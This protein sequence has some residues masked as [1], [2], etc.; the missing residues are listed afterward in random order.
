MSRTFPGVPGG[1]LLAQGLAD[2]ARGVPSLAACLVAM[3]G[4]RLETLGLLAAGAVD[5][6][7]TG[8]AFELAAYRLLAVDHGV[9][10]HGRFNALARELDSG[11]RVLARDV[12]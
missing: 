5:A 6:V 7:R 12:R 9:A 11:L 8:E 4:P 1:E 2:I 3:A 10:A